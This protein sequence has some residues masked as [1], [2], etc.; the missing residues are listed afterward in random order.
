M[1]DQEYER[2]VDYLQGMIADGV[3]LVH[4]GNLFDWSDTNILDLLIEIQ[5]KKNEIKDLECQ[6]GDLLQ[7][8]FTGQKA[9]VAYIDDHT[10]HL[11]PADKLVRFPKDKI[12]YQYKKSTPGE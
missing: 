9:G 1:L 11:L 3:Q 7:N 10:V 8:R 6:V 5:E 2:L 12:W 4:G